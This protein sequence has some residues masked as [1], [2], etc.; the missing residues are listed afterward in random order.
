MSVD[1][2]YWEPLAPQDVAELFRS[3]SR[4]W[5]IAGGYSIDAFIGAF[6]RRHHEDIDVGLLARDQ[7]A[8]Q[9]HLAGWDLYCADPPGS[10]RPWNEREILAE[11]VHDVWAR[12]HAGGPWKLQLML[13]PAEGDDWVYRRDPRIRL[14][15]PEL[16][17]M[18]D[19]IPYLAPEIQLLFKAKAPRQRD[20]RDFA[21]SLPLLDA[22]Q[23]EWLRDGIRLG[24]PA[25]PWLARL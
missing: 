9:A 19:A 22:R 24:N 23:R 5:W 25:H 18:H 12:E 11:P 20:E 14:P 1:L 15:L 17:R 8:V 16:V 6:D 13:N 4:E 3:Y 2:E 21:D 10:L 7:A